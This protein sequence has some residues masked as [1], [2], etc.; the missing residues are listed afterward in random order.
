MTRR[1][2]LFSAISG[3][4]T[5]CSWCI[6]FLG[7]YIQIALRGAKLDYYFSTRWNG[8]WYRIVGVVARGGY[9]DVYQCSI[10][11][12]FGALS[13]SHVAVKALRDISDLES[14]RRFQHE[15][16]TQRRLRHP[17]LLSIIDFNLNHKPPYFVMPLMKETL[18]NRLA[19]MHRVNHV[20]RAKPALDDVLLPLCR[21]ISYL[22]SNRIY[23]RDIKPA[24]IFFDF[25]GRTKLGDLGI[26]HGNLRALLVQTQGG[27]G[28][29]G[30]TAPETLR[31]GI[32]SPQSDVYS[33]GIVLGEMITGRKL[34]LRWWY[35]RNNWPSV[36]HPRSCHH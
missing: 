14:A 34:P 26:C 11:S 2:G 28:T 29:H 32:A 12:Q 22:H 3:P 30:Y 19:R 15:V 31:T 36:Q 8:R 35:N 24:N 5:R 16:I 9:G 1:Y 6:H 27:I 10:V 23:H 25:H 7:V 4:L 21:V 18:A 13:Q 17:N 20:F 33:L